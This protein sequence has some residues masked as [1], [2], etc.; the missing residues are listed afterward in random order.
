MILKDTKKVEVSKGLPQPELSL[1]V[2]DIKE[3]AILEKSEK[4][5]TILKAK[6]T[7]LKENFDSEKKRL[8]DMSKK[9]IDMKQ[10]LDKVQ[11][12]DQEIRE[13]KLDKEIDSEHK[14]Y[15]EKIHKEMYDIMADAEKAKT[16]LKDIS[17]KEETVNEL[18]NQPE[19]QRP[20]NKNDNIKKSSDSQKSKGVRIL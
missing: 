16:L 13:Q 14:K 20:L 3:E 18:L 19:V 11:S 9:L 2:T 10:R 4:K 8:T 7:D 17:K 12:K 15:F 6:K 1:P 5:E